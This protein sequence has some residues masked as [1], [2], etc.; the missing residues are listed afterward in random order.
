[1]LDADVEEKLHK[2][3]PRSRGNIFSSLMIR[4]HNLHFLTQ[5][6][7]E[8]VI[9]VTRAHPATN[10]GWL[11]RVFIMV[12]VP[13][14]FWNT[15]I[16]FLVQIPVLTYERTLLILAIYYMIV[17]GSAFTG[18]MKWYF[19]I[20]IV[21]NKRILDY[22][23]MPFSQYKVSEANLTDIEDVTQRQIGFFPAIFN[24]GNLV[25]QTAAE[26]MQFEFEKVP[27]PGWLRDKIVDLAEILK[28][29]SPRK[30]TP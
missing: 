8:D 9:I 21:T 30:N 6:D 20:Y 7:D 19:N 16:N 28:K 18:F 24:Y 5:D 13:L 23:F 29:I 1:M 11:I 12:F 22:D 4:P 15:I 27:N 14:I 10:L 17:Y 2:V 26:R 3:F 25:I